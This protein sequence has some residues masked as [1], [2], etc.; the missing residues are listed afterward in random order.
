MW[1]KRSKVWGIILVVL[2]TVSCSD[3]VK[4]ELESLAPSV[5]KKIED[6]NTKLD[7]NDLTNAI[8]LKDYAKK[9]KKTHPEYTSVANEFLKETKPDNDRIVSM[10][11]RFK[12]IMDE[13]KK[14]RSHKERLIEMASL[15]NASDSQIYNDSLI[16]PINT[17]ADLSQGSLQRLQESRSK[18][19]ADEVSRLVGNPNYGR[20]ENRGG[21][22]IWVW[23]AAYSIFN[24]LTTPY[25]YHSWYYNRPW[26]Y[27]HDYGRDIYSGRADRRNRERTHSSNQRKLKDYGRSRGR[28][29]Y[30]Y[31]SRKNNSN[32][33]AS[34]STR[35]AHRNSVSTTRNRSSYSASH[36]G[37]NRS[38]GSRFGGFRGK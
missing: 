25:Y 21:Q 7:N 6:L 14:F 26:S 35:N 1:L 4:D 13:P 5:S 15:A 9:L 19:N 27:Y 38:G 16:D 37:G 20:W 29:Y 24:N 17:M 30:S 3:P 36:R 2:V 8:I 11:K 22:S 12:E 34:T 31:N 18:R 23:L 28:N 32:F 33:R 10:E